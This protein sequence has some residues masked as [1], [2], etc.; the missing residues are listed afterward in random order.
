MQEGKFSYLSL[1]KPRIAIRHEQ[2]SLW[3]FVREYTSWSR[4]RQR[5]SLIFPKYFI[6]ICFPCILVSPGEVSLIWYFSA[7]LTTPSWTNTRTTVSPFLWILQD[8]AGSRF[9]LCA[10]PSA[11]TMKPFVLYC[12]GCIP[13]QFI[14]VFLAKM[15]VYWVRG[16]R[17]RSGYHGNGNRACRTAMSKI[18]CSHTAAV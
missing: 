8:T 5:Q 3:Q 4:G 18:A 16:W 11:H 1:P 7:R 17:C 6:P 15:L 12:L 2:V 14:C 10:Y 9:P 13:A